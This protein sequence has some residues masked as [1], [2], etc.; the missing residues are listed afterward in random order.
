MDAA[1]HAERPGER[2]VHGGGAL[3]ADLQRRVDHEL[4]VTGRGPVARPLVE[5]QV[6]QRLDDVGAVAAQRSEDVDDQPVLGAS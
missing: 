3:L 1:R 5:A 6:V 2:E 4:P